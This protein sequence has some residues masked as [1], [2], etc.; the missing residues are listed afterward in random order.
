MHALVGWDM[1]DAL[2]RGAIVHGAVAAAVIAVP[3]GVVSSLVG[4]TSSLRGPML[5][6]I[7]FGMVVG[8]FVAGRDRPER[9]LVHGGLAALAVYVTVQTIGVVLRLARGATLAWLTYPLVALLSISC[10][11]MGGYLAFRRAG[12]GST[13]FQGEPE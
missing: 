4:E 13:S 1:T 6:V 12:R 11:I 7:V 10:G 8:G 9:A 3:A 2:D 5:L